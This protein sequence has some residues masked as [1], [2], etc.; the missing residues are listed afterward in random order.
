MTFSLTHL[1]LIVAAAVTV[2]AVVVAAGMRRRDNRRLSFMLDALEDGEL[3][4][5]FLENSRFNRTLNRIR[6][7]FEQQRQQG[8]QESWVKLI[9][10][11][12]HEIM[13]TV[14]PIASLSDALSK[15]PDVD[16]NNSD[17]KN[18]LAI[19]SEA[20][21]HLIGFVENYR[22]LAG[23][24]APVR[25][26][27]VLQTL[28]DKVLALNH[29]QLENSGV[30]CSSHTDDTGIVIYADE[31]QISQIFI[32]LI[33]NAIQAGAST[34]DINV[35]SVREGG[36]DTVSVTVAN[37]GAPIPLAVQEQI[38]TPFYTT[39]PKGSGIGCAI[40]RQIMLGHGGSLSL[41]GSD[42]EQTVFRLVFR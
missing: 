22:Q 39:K 40:A 24:G 5:R 13:N 19:I 2:T 3:N 27:V 16:E 18:G 17:M 25:R 1:L 37:N 41:V 21:Q 12:T 35:R 9:R 26:A 36:D 42:N 8:E 20:S 32:N 31:G 34:I 38:F 15:L 6:T 7:L 29:E 33:L 4:F 10:V 23:V 28:I 30:T 14:A 11:L